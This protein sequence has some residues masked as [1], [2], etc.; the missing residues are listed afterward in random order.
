MLQRAVQLK[1]SCT[2][3]IRENEDARKF[4]LTK[5]EWN[6][7]INI[8]QLLEPLSLA[9][10][11]LIKSLYPSLNSAL[12]VYMVLV[13]HLKTVQKGLYDQSQLI[14][15]ATQIIEKID[16]YLR[17][18][19]EK[20]SAKQYEEKQTDDLVELQGTSS[21]KQSKK[22]KSKP[23]IFEQEMFSTANPIDNVQGEIKRYLDQETEDKDINILDYWRAIPATSAPSERVF[24]QGR[25]VVS[26][27]RSALQPDTIE[28]ILCVKA[29]YKFFGG[30]PPK[31]SSSL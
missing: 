23:N 3:Y 24:S 18:A 7:T 26:W 2:Q 11:M 6:Q 9:T 12:P 10:H 14:S 25:A 19:L 22:Q 1:R 20:P 30:P 13:K 29:W 17:K 15:P 21:P 27:Q 4:S 8:M 16:G 28:Q 5:D 31:P